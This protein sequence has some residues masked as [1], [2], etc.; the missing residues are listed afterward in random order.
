MNEFVRNI[1]VVIGINQYRNG[2]KPLQNAVNDAQA[3]A[4]LLETK[5][6]YEVLPFLD[7]DAS[8]E[9][10]RDLIKTK[11][12]DLVTA[13]DRLLF[14][15]AGHG[16]ATSSD[17]IPDGFLI[18]CDADP[19]NQ[20][21][22]LPM[23]ELQIALEDLPCRHFLGILDCCYSGAIRWGN[24]RRDL[25]TAPEVIYQEHYNRFIQSQAWQFITSAAADQTASDGWSRSD[26]RGQGKHSPFATA[27]IEG[28][29]GAADIPSRK[30]GRK[31]IGDG[32]ITATELCLYLGNRVEVLIGADRDRQTPQ[33]WPMKRHGSGEF[34]FFAD[35]KQPQLESIGRLDESRNPYRG[36]ESFEEEH[37]NL[38]FGRDAIVV[39]LQ[40]F[41]QKNQLTVVLGASGSGKSSLVKAGLI[42]KL[43]AEG[44]TK[45]QTIVIRPGKSPLA[46]LSYALNPVLNS[47]T[48]FTTLISNWRQQ[49]PGV[50]LLLVIDQCEELIT[51]CQDKQESS[52]FL[53]ELRTAIAAHSNILSVILTLRSD[54][55][56]Q[57]QDSTL[58]DLW[59]DGRFN[60]PVMSRSE[61]QDAI[62]KPAETLAIYF[63][64]DE[65]VDQL[66]DDVADMPGSLPLLS[67][68]LSE[69]YLKYLKR[70]DYRSL[71][72]VITQADYD[73]LGGVTRSLTQ[74]ADQEYDCL[75]SD[76]AQTVKTV[77]LRMVAV[78]S[79]ELARRRVSDAEL[80][81]PPAKAEQVKTVIDRFSAARLLVKGQDVEGNPYVEPAHDALIQGWGKLRDWVNAEKNLDL[82]RRLTPAALTWKTAQQ[83]RF[84]WN[85]DPYLEVAEQRSPE[86]TRT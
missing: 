77:M 25:L 38:F 6:Q 84:L 70:Q 75:G 23:T 30:L 73:E 22:W 49:N 14:Y 53:I 64:S 20:E 19:V 5:H 40:T 29:E 71:D 28:F 72:R 56:P 33:L 8:L 60:V 65:L 24:S 32:I 35:G 69:L 15:F 80:S 18:P 62:E 61:L 66:I 79:G 44:Q 57:L 41:V 76:Y 83:R 55:E 9:K 50:K 3:I 59:Q 67:F 86:L 34:I 82:Q 17:D 10:L 52:R 58:Q 68:A 16:K 36:L 7:Q 13:D 85:A 45:L 78:G 51:L 21:T 37:Q 43:Q 81:Y 54:F 31:Q 39:E 11:L 1:A 46:M 4:E 48:P 74:R 12:R 47:Q 26:D 2:I 63:E 42:P 27:L